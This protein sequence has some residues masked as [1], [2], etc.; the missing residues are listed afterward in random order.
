MSQADSTRLSM[1]STRVSPPQAIAPTEKSYC[2]SLKASLHA[3]VFS[4]M[5]QPAA[6]RLVSS[7]LLKSFCFNSVFL[8]RSSSLRVSSHC[9]LS[10]PPHPLCTFVLFLPERDLTLC[11]TGVCALGVG[12]WKML[13]V[14]KYGTGAVSEA[15]IMDCEGE[16]GGRSLPKVPDLADCCPDIEKE[17]PTRSI[18]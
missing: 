16:G 11:P 15:G 1:T 18:F 6:S 13:Q 17:E 2:H 3:P 7:S 9:F 10:P 12:L 4:N 8:I 5:H 14:A